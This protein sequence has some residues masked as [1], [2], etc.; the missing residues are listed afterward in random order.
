MA[1]SLFRTPLS[2]SPELDN[3]KPTPHPGSGDKSSLSNAPD[4]ARPGLDSPSD[5]PPAP[6][7]SR[8]PR[9]YGLDS[10]RAIAVVM[11]LIYHFLPSVLPGGYVGVDVFFVLSGFLITSL[12]VQEWGRTGAISLGNFWKR[13][14]RRIL[15]ALTLMVVSVTAV[16]GAVGGDALLNIGRQ[17]VGAFTFSSNWL[18]IA[19]DSSYAGQ[20]VPAIFNNLWSLAVEEQFYVLWPLVVMGLAFLASRGVRR[21]TLMRTGA[22]VSIVV[23]LASLA[24][25]ISMFTST[26]D[27]SRVYLG[28]DT[29]LFGLMIGAFVA[30]VVRPDAQM[31]WPKLT[32]GPFGSPARE[33]R[34]LSTIVLASS[35]ALVIVGAGFFLPFDSA[36]PFLGGLFAVDIAT[37]VLIVLF[38]SNQNQAQRIE[39]APVRWI[40]QRSYGLYLWHWPLVVLAA[41]I[42]Q[43][44]NAGTDIELGTFAVSVALTFGLAALS[45][46]Y[47]EKPILDRG[48]ITCLKGWSIQAAAVLRSAFPPEGLSGKDLV[49]KLAPAVVLVATIAL[50]GVGVV[51]A[52]VHQPENSSVSDSIQAG[53][54]ALDKA[55]AEAESESSKEPAGPASQGEDPAD[56]DRDKGKDS[57]EGKDSE[58]GKPVAPAPKPKTPSGKQVTIIGDSVTLASAPGILEALPGAKVDAEE[59]RMFSAAPK[60]VKDLERKGQLRDFVVI[61]LATNGTVRPSEI[62]AV[63]KASGDRQIILVTG[64]AERSWVKGAN[65]AIAKAAE[66]YENVHVADWNKAIAKHEKELARD[67]IH[68]GIEGGERYAKTVKSALAKAN[69]AR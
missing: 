69:V 42:M 29:H 65:K 33:V 5:E 57:A 63:R 26:S 59:S 55:A 61:S 18:D 52:L 14:A 30:F 28:T 6:T 20:L 66:K 11:V 15:P 31:R 64:H 16:A 62:E 51:S 37:A 39:V 68:P 40:G 44:Q 13:R 46:R 22:T 24:L 43:D 9:L 8:A 47:V 25:M 53:Q 48:L 12:L 60:I 27:A 50:T 54:A 32:W 23:A 3:P 4:A 1:S 45:F 35:C 67:G 21:C 56:G 34:L 58:E 36:V 38:I 41:Q 10:L 19:F 49:F 7:P 17:L 2:T